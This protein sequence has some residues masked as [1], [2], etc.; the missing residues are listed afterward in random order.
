MQSTDYLLEHFCKPEFYVSDVLSVVTICKYEKVWVLGKQAFYM[1]TWQLAI[2]PSCGIGDW[3]RATVESE[4]MEWNDRHTH[5]HTVYKQYTHHGRVRVRYGKVY[6]TLISKYQPLFTCYQYANFQTYSFNI[7]IFFLHF[8]GFH[9]GFL[10]CKLKMQIK[11]ELLLG[12]SNQAGVQS[13]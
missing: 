3:A 8:L 9:S 11:T 6:V 13:S 12:S 1:P 7:S 4:P 2:W 10:M 5:T